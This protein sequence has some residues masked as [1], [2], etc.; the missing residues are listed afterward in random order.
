VRRGGEGKRE[1][2]GWEREGGNMSARR[3]GR[4]SAG[5]WGGG[6]PAA[7]A[8]TSAVNCTEKWYFSS[9]FFQ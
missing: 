2:G 4:E 7:A 8:L 1:R 3:A 6:G 5:C 9:Y